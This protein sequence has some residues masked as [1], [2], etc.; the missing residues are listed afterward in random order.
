[1]ATRRR[2]F[3]VKQEHKSATDPELVTILQWH[4][5]LKPLAIQESTACDSKFLYKKHTCPSDNT[6]VPSAHSGV[7][8]NNID[9]S[10]RTP[11]NSFRAI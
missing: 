3:L 8:Q 5:S 6:G 1:M 11:Q 7:P 9:V 2:C 4:T 10:L